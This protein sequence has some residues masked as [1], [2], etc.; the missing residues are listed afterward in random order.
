MLHVILKNH[1]VWVLHGKTILHIYMQVP[2]QVCI[3]DIK[4]H[5]AYTTSIRAASNTCHYHGHKPANRWEWR[6]GWKLQIWENVMKMWDKNSSAVTTQRKP[7]IDSQP[8]R[9]LPTKSFGSGWD[10]VSFNLRLWTHAEVG[11]TGLLGAPACWQG[12]TEWLRP[13]TFEIFAVFKVAMMVGFFEFSNFWDLPSGCWKYDSHIQTLG[14]WQCGIKTGVGNPIK[15]YHCL[16]A[17]REAWKP[18]STSVNCLAFK[19]SHPTRSCYAG[20]KKK[21]KSQ[22]RPLQSPWLPWSCTD[23]DKRSVVTGV[24]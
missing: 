20:A 23:R 17:Q 7:Y 19:D 3:L 13:K 24:V 18:V 5:A 4:L 15:V 12:L 10:I 6:S 1:R 22:Q 21:E 8:R 2:A 11:K 16:K 9:S 14:R